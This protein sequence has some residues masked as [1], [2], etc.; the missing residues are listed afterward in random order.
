M[1]AHII[2]GG[3]IQA[4]LVLLHLTLD[5]TDPP[6]DTLLA[7]VAVLSPLRAGPL[8]GRVTAAAELDVVDGRVVTKYPLMGLHADLESGE[9]A[10]GAVLRL[11]PLSKAGQIKLEFSSLLSIILLVAQQVGH[12]IRG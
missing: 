11:G 10:G 1:E 9:H 2:E 5:A 6:V 3:V 8:Q 7:P 12:N 4:V